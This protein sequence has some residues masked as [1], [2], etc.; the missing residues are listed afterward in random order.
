[1][2]QALFASRANATAA[3]EI[4]AYYFNHTLISTEYRFAQHV[5]SLQLIIRLARVC[6]CIHRDPWLG[7]FHG[8]ELILV[9]QY[10]P[11]ILSPAEVELSNAFIQ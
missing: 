5:S 2:E 1:M 8:S 3:V 4:F 6:F 11:L 9:F 7:V 10:S